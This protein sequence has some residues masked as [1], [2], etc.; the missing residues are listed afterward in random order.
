MITTGVPAASLLAT[1]GSEPMDLAT[2]FGER[3]GTRLKI[4]VAD[5][6][7]SLTLSIAR[8]AMPFCAGLAGSAVA[9]L[10]VPAAPVVAEPVAVGEPTVAAAPLVD[11]AACGL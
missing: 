8:P 2:P 6:A 3:Q 7:T 11:G 10:P 1:C 9:T 5:F 4:S